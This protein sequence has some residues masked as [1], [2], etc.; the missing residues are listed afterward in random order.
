MRLTPL[1]EQIWYQNRP[2]PLRLLLRPLS[3]LYRLLWTL[4]V[5]RY[6]RFKPNAL[7]VPVLVVG[8]LTVGG[9]GKTPLLIALSQALVARG[10]RPGIISR[11]YGSQAPHYP[12][13]VTAQARA[14]QAGDEPLLIALKTGLPVV[15]DAQR[16]RAAQYLLQHYDCNLLLSDDGLQHLALARDRELIVIDGQRRLGNGEL[17]PLGPCREP[18]R[19]GDWLVTRDGGPEDAWPLPIVPER[20][21]SLDGRQ[22]I[23]L[24]DW[25]G[26]SVHAVAG[27]GFPDRFFAT[28]RAAGL[29]VMEHP[30][31]DHHQF[32]V[33]ELEFTPVLPI[34]MTEKDAVKCRS[35]PLTDAWYLAIQ[36]QLPEALVE[37][38]DLTLQQTAEA[39]HG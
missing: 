32:Q 30:F 38:I 10:W 36:A 31:D 11:G 26:R 20:L 21:Y 28:L 24:A 34:L 17:L 9:T 6:R 27:I 4:K 14:D 37:Q 29:Q 5:W 18:R 19:A 25:H 7:P 22:A 8:N 15:I 39:K 1:L 33:G 2:H 23:D 12:F 35:L 3:W 13:A 16:S